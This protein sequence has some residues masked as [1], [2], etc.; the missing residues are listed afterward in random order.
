[1]FHLSFVVALSVTILLV[2]PTLSRAQLGGINGLYMTKERR[3]YRNE[4]KQLRT[5][6]GFLK[7]ARGASEGPSL[8][9]TIFQEYTV[10]EG[11]DKYPTC[12]RKSA[13]LADALL[14]KWP[15]AGNVTVT[16]IRMQADNRCWLA[17][18]VTP[19]TNTTMEGDIQAALAQN[20]TVTA[21]CS[22]V[23]SYC[24]AMGDLNA[25]FVSFQYNVNEYPVDEVD[26][27]CKP[28]Y[29]DQ[30]LDHFDPAVT[31]TFPQLYYVCNKTWPADPAVQAKNATILFMQ[32]A[33]GGI[34]IPSYSMI[35]YEH[36][37]RLNALVLSLEHRYYGESMPEGTTYGTV[38]N[39][40]M[41]W[42]TVEQTIE[43]SAYFL[44]T[45]RE[46]LK[47]PAATP[48]VV[49]G[50]SYGGE[51]AA[52][53]R[54]AK[55]DLFAAA[56]ASSP[57]IYYVFGTPMWA[58]TSDNFHNVVTSAAEAG[59]P[60]CAA[61][62]KAAFEAMLVLST[63]KAGLVELATKMNLCKPKTALKY[64]AG[65]FNMASWLHDD[66]LVGRAQYDNGPPRY[67]E[68]ASVCRKMLKATA[69]NP[70]DPIAAI[71]ATAS[72]FSTFD[73]YLD[74]KTGCFTLKDSSKVVQLV[75]KSVDWQ[76]YAYQCCTQGAVHSGMLNSVS[77]AND[78]FVSFNVSA[79]VLQPQCNK[80]Y[81]RKVPQLK[82]ASVMA[83]GPKL[84]SQ[85][86][87]VVFVNGQLDGWSG[88]SPKSTADLAPTGPVGLAYVTYPRGSHCTDFNDYNPL[89]PSEWKPLRRQAMDAAV[90]FAEVWRQARL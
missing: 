32:G 39:P 74:P 60:G 40:K 88:G 52:W 37:R 86:G 25:T 47:V 79:A 80:I 89:G 28:D 2:S 53:I 49:I 63:T 69:A 65:G 16:N 7:S 84:I 27:Q 56:W 82:P 76:S 66:L 78:A 38:P 70:N 43:D 22:L 8:E 23:D 33:E 11:V 71:M 34:G 10:P 19:D 46:T 75:Y 90:G 59:A 29:F 36:A 67:N 30:K 68:T 12:P 55:P 1:M 45:M 85:V 14:A 51:L 54:A 24:K 87:G 81:S 15:D 18:T 44:T 17:T 3:E 13:A 6:R 83:D 4:M 58:E 62:F 73:D 5:T 26:L 21:F 50:G 48:A 31:A 35:I 42:L 9:F 20:D 57:P 61:A 77:D 64:A 41:K 72:Y